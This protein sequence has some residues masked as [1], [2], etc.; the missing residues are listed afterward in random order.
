[1]QIH[2]EG[3][4]TNRA[5]TPLDRG[6]GAIHAMGAD[7]RQHLG[8]DGGETSLRSA[9]ARLMGRWCCCLNCW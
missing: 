5:V 8:G 2:P 1:M 7:A 9:Q 6:K 3:L 4:G